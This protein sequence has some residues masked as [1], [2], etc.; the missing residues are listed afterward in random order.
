MRQGRIIS[1]LVALVII[2][3]LGLA[4][5]NPGITVKVREGDTLWDLAQEYLKDPYRWREIWKDNPGVS[6]P[7]LI[8]PGNTLY[9]PVEYVREDAA[10]KEAKAQAGLLKEELSVLRDNLSTQREIS[11]LIRQ[12]KEA[13]IIAIQRRIGEL[14][15]L[16]IGLQRTLSIQKVDL[17]NKQNIVAKQEMLI[18]DQLKEVNQLREELRGENNLSV[19]LGIDLTAKEEALA[20]RNNEVKELKERVESQIEEIGLL[21][22]D[23]EGLDREVKFCKAELA[24]KEIIL[25]Q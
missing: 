14:K 7:N 23:L 5:A 22:K 10:I 21:T 6:N 16:V 20:N 13:E 4:Q 1:L 24:Q 9:I 17:E 19:S 18:R 15:E 2:F 12:E 8:Y 25:A 11:A 3:S